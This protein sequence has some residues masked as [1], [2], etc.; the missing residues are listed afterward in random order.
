LPW[1][2]QLYLCFCR[3]L[4]QQSRDTG[5]FVLEVFAGI[6]TGILIGLALY[7]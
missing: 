3:D 1:Y 7:E 2:W 6:L 4:M 5:T